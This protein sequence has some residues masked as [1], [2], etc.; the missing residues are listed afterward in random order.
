M[1]ARIVM[2]NFS[3]AQLLVQQLTTAPSTTYTRGCGLWKK[4]ERK[5]VRGGCGGKEGKRV[6]IGKENTVG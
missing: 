2:F 6:T 5:D 3:A 4:E 1:A